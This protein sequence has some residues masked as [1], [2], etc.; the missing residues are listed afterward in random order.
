MPGPYVNCTPCADSCPRQWLFLGLSVKSFSG[1]MQA[2]GGGGNVTVV[3]VEDPK[4]VC[5]EN[6]PKL[7]LDE[8]FQTQEWTGADPGFIGESQN[9]IGVPVCFK[10]GDFEFSGIVQK[11]S[12]DDSTGGLNIYTVDISA[13]TDILNSIS[14]ILDDYKGGTFTV[15][16]V[17]NAY[18]L[19]E[20]Q[21]CA[22]FG[23]ASNYGKGMPWVK[24]RT[25]VVLLS[26]LVANTGSIPTSNFL[27][28][29]RIKFI[30][31]LSG[32]F[33]L[34]REDDVGYILDI[35]EVPIAPDYYRFEGQSAILGDMISQVIEDAGMEFM[36]ELIPV[37]EDNT[38]YK[39]IKIRTIDR[40]GPI[41]S[42]TLAQFLDSYNSGCGRISAN[43]GEELR[44]GTFNNFTLGPRKEQMYYVENVR[45]TNG[46]SETT[47]EYWNPTT[48][49][50]EEVDIYNYDLSDDFIQP[51]WG[52]DNNGNVLMS[53]GI[54]WCT[55]NGVD[56]NLDAKT[57]TSDP[58]TVYFDANTA[59]LKYQTVVLNV[60][61]YIELEE[62]ELIAALDGEESWKSYVFT[63]NR[64]TAQL[65][66]AVHSVGNATS[67]LG[68][69][70]M[71]HWM[72]V[73]NNSPAV[74]NQI[75]KPFHYLNLKKVKTAQDLQNL[76]EN[77]EDLLYNWVLDL[78]SNYYGKK[79]Q[80][81][82]PWLCAKRDPDT[83]EI[84]FSRSVSDGGW[85]E[86][87]GTE[88]FNLL[89]IDTTSV[90][91]D[92]FRL[93]DG[94]IRPFVRYDSGQTIDFKNLDEDQYG[95]VDFNSGNYGILWAKCSTQSQ[96]V[97]GDAANLTDPRVV[98]ELPQSI[99]E[100]GQFDLWNRNGKVI[101]G[102]NPILRQAQQEA[103]PSVRSVG[104]ST[105]SL[106]SAR[107]PRTPSAATVALTNN[108]EV[109]GPWYFGNGSGPTA[110]NSDYS[111]TPWNFGSMTALNAAALDQ[112]TFGVSTMYKSQSGT[113]TVPGIPKG[114]LGEEM[115][116]F[117]G[118][119]YIAGQRIIATRTMTSNSSLSFPG[120]TWGTVDLMAVGWTGTLGPII[121]S[122]NINYGAD[123]IT[124]TYVFQLY[125]KG[126]RR[127]AKAKI[128]RV[129]EIGNIRQELFNKFGTGQK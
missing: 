66:R 114:R 97:F 122:M 44:I 4:A 120:I 58:V 25:A 32:G 93:G 79:F 28:N 65:L 83:G 40:T 85:N 126:F 96:F 106:W 53:R 60:P 113:I 107:R 13:P 121:S 69:W 95:Y 119:G 62:Y 72:T 125:T 27:Q 86:D 48:Q 39:F 17:I 98:I 87:S 38:V 71:A 51:Y 74:A 50:F 118:S 19:W 24:I 26:G 67:Q 9:L 5:P 43:V 23:G 22:S 109:Y 102:T 41:T 76:I 103:D 31:G 99:N 11:V 123:G 88:F 91:M 68:L 117:N 14:V 128:D 15:P 104:G 52:L 73:M 84:T 1:D 16:N 42:Y 90:A 12:K 112:V 59:A 80:V 61:D 100:K 29:N 8:C 49:E 6:L 33:G 116:A 105:V 34:I 45:G 36:V 127:F 3:L 54:D 115:M 82:I 94:R 110:V 77:D 18:G 2:L 81:R 111:L 20:Y 78:A 64:P 63:H 124:T 56:L 35:S 21:A 129:K 7:Y 89:G 75:L 46:Y 10:H 37:C 47:G 70:D 108:E 30:P 92:F 57:M 101:D 55:P